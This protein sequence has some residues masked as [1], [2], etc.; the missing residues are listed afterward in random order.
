[1]QTPQPGQPIPV[2][3]LVRVS[4]TRQETSRQIHEL[5]AVAA[6]KGWKV[7]ETCEETVSGSA[8]LEDRP[9]IRRL[10]ELAAAGEIRKVLVHE[11]SR[12]A[13]RPS[14]ALTFVEV[15]EGCGVSLYWHAQSIETL[16][17]SGKRN[18]AAAIMLALLS[19]MARSERDTLRE[20][21]VSG[22]DEARRRGR[23]IGRPLGT[24][25]TDA[26][27][28]LRHKKVVRLLHDGMSVRNAAK[29]GGV[30][31]NTVSKVRQVIQAMARAE[32]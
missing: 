25:M 26:Q 1:M 4:T 2:A 17:P 12:V 16:L 28:L 21:I 19:E 9:A 7:V 5:N 3:L 20:R 31:K 27:L 22:M 11:V 6:S 23:N 29:L 18:P 14:V 13:R 30:N 10:V 15:L 8:N 32:T 24:Q